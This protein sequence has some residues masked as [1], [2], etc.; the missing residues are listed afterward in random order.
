MAESPLNMLDRTR[1]RFSWIDLVLILFLA[2]LAFIPPIDEIH[3]QFI[4]LA[5]VI[6]QLFEGRLVAWNPQSGPALSVGIKIVLAT[7]LLDHTGEMGIN[8]PFY[9]IYYLPIVTAAIYFGPVATL[10]WTALTSAAY[11]SFLIPALQEYE[12]SPESATLLSLRILFFFLVAVLVNRFVVENRRQVARYQALSETLEE[13][14]RQLRRAEADARR[15]ERLAALG[16]LSAGL[17]HEI[18]NPL[19]VIK[20]SAEMLAQK[21]ESSQPLARELAGYISSEVN[22]LN[23]LV[24]RFLDFARPLQ[25]EL[26]PVRVPELLDACF[27]AAHAQFPAANVRV[28][29]D[30]APDLPEI[31]ADRQ[32][33]ELLFVNLIVNAYQAMDGATDAV[34]DAQAPGHPRKQQGVLRL[35]AARGTSNGHAGVAVVIRDSGPGVPDELR[36]QIFNPF[37]TSKKEGVGLGLAIVAKIAD[38]H[39]GS[40]KLE[41]NPGRGASFH[42]FLPAKPE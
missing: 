23:A 36:E 13:T 15:A 40:V 27:E 17:A 42:V 4:L 28:E 21:L 18:R 41:K 10:F 12:F 33:C 14:N 20:G 19:G 9:P 3:K 6:F 29:R 25:V 22:R 39:R 31:L 16:Q 26:R 1:S 8:S 2:G 32:L 34:G 24:S 30:Y 11:C 7:L 5:I 35:S 38:N 37:F